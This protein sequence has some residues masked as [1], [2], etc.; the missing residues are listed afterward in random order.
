MFKLL[1]NEVQCVILHRNSQSTS[2][3]QWSS[4]PVQSSDCIQPNPNADWKPIVIHCGIMKA[5][6]HWRPHVVTQAYSRVSMLLPYFYKN[7]GAKTTDDIEFRICGDSG[8]VDE[9][10]HVSIIE[11]YIR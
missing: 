8:I 9:D 4:P 10:V 5:V 2:P 3:V 6:A 7:L 11:L 1:I